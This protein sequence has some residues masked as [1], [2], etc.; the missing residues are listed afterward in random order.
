MEKHIDDYRINGED[1]GSIKIID[2]GSDMSN[3]W[4]FAVRY[5]LS[6]GFAVKTDGVILDQTN[7]KAI[8]ES[9]R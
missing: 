7:F 1:D 6:K 3:V 2:F 4:D 9:K 5:F 8:K